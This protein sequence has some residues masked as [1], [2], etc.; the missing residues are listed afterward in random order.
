MD[1]KALVLQTEVS[2]QM[3]HW[4]GA[5]RAPVGSV[6]RRGEVEWPVTLYWLLPLFWRNTGNS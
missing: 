5:T 1:P 2:G 6:V 4:R 3:L